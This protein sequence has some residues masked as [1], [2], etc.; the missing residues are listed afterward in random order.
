MALAERPAAARQLDGVD[1]IH[2][3]TILEAAAAAPNSNDD[4]ILEYDTLA[5]QWKEMAKMM[6]NRSG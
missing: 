3:H 6:E 1:D 2:M 4:D 5:G